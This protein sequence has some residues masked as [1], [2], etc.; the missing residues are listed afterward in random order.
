MKTVRSWSYFRSL[1]KRPVAEVIPGYGG[2]STSGTPSDVRDLRGVQGS[3]A[4]ERDERE[5]A[6]VVALLDRA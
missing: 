2:T 6:R 4:S 3:S 5:V 1:V